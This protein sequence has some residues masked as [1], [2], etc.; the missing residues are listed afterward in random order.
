MDQSYFVVCGGK[1]IGPFEAVDRIHWIDNRTVAV[2]TREENEFWWRT[3][4]LDE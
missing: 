4:T 3:M 2:G 1:K